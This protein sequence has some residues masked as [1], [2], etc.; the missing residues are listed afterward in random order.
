MKTLLLLLLIL[1]PGM[2]LAEQAEIKM[3]IAP[4]KL[5]EAKTTLD[6]KASEAPEVRVCFFD[7]AEAALNEKKLILR[8]R[9][10]EKANQAGKKD[11]DAVVKLRGTKTAPDGWEELKPEEDWVGPDAA[12]DVKPSFSIKEEGL[13]EARMRKV[14]DGALAVKEVL[15][16]Q[17]REF[18]AACLGW[19]RKAFPWPDLKRYGVIE[20]WKSKRDWGAFKKVT[21]ELW[22]LAKDGKEPMELLEISVKTKEG[23]AKPAAEVA[24]EFYAAAAQAGLGKA[25]GES[26]T[27]KVI[28]YF[29]PGR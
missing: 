17:Q 4:D 26:K 13:D 18:C 11:V 2:L 27:Q 3:L 7:T 6:I 15:S 1:A 5:G 29:K 21:V 10:E 8:V 24:R 12:K 22:R 9:L 25:T 20:V 23:D 16:D 14:M 28:D 19:K